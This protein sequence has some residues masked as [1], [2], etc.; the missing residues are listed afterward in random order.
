MTSDGV[1]R[2]ADDVTRRALLGM[3]GAALAATVLGAGCSTSSGGNPGPSGASTTARSPRSARR[4]PLRPGTPD[5]AAMAGWI[6]EIVD[7][8]IRRPGHPGDTR[9]VEWLIDR[10]DELGLE[11]VRAEGFTTNRFDAKDASLDVVAGGKTEHLECYPVA[12][13]SSGDG[14]TLELVPFDR[15]HPETMRGKAVF[16]LMEMTRIPASVMAKLGSVDPDQPWQ[17]RVVDERHT[18]DAETIVSSFDDAQSPVDAAAEAGALAFIGVWINQPGNTCRHYMPYQGRQQPIPGVWIRPTDGLRLQRLLADGEVQVRLTQTTSS[19]AVTSHMV[20]GELPGR[21][22][23]QVIVGSHHD[24]PWASAVE[25]ASG[26]A[27]VLAQAA[28]WAAVPAAERP[29]RMVFVLQGGHFANVTAGY[30]I[31]HEDDLDQVVLEVHLEHVGRSVRIP[32]SPTDTDHAPLK[33]LDDPFPRWWFV[34][35]VGDLR[36]RTLAI[37]RDE[38][39][40]RSLVLAPDAVGGLPPTDAAG[41]FYRDVPCV[42]F[43]AAPD[44]LFDETDTPDKVHR[45]SLNP[46]TRAVVRILEQTRGV[47][48]QAMRR[49]A[50]DW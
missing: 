15:D 26:V 29:H 14:R 38:G 27:L 4:V 24:A 21:D 6:D 37:I 5:E 35:P 18:L 9:T 34:S 8:G 30:A 32:A 23:S 47:S 17:D 3:G 1:N 19:Q 44:Y 45:P 10:F 41:F 42:S 39:I 46:V 13:T 16:R 49:P 12:Y 50:T 48:P 25:D 11:H 7:F 36:S 43:L 40:D 20:V 31:D 2:R 28:H 22:E 33:V